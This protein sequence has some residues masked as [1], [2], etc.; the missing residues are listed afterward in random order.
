MACSRNEQGAAGAAASVP[1]NG[2][3]VVLAMPLEPATLLAPFA[4]NDSEVNISAL[5]FPWLTSL[6]FRG[7]LVHTP[8]LAQR[9]ERSA[10]G[11]SITYY[12]KPAKWSDGAPVRASDAVFTWKLVANVEFGSPK[13]EYTKRIEAME[14]VSDHV[15][16]VTF[17]NAYWMDNQLSD[18]NLGVIP[19]HVYKNLEPR[20]VRGNDRVLV[21]VGHGPFRV[22]RREGVKMF[23]LER[24]PEC[25]ISPVPHL[26]QLIFTFVGT[27]EAQR[28]ALMTGAVDAIDTSRM[29]DVEEILKKG[30]FEAAPRGTRAIEFIT[31]NNTHPLFKDTKVRRALTASLD[32]DGMNASVFRVKKAGVY[33]KSCGT[34]PPVLMKAT[35]GEPGWIPFDRAG[36]GA[37]L[38]DL[39]WKRGATGV[40][41]REGKKFEFTLLVNVETPRRVQYAR[42]I[43]QDLREAGIGVSIEELSFDALSARINERKFEAAIFGYTASLQLKQGE[44][45]GTGQNFNFA[46]YSNPAVDALNAGMRDE[47]DEGR[48]CAALRQM[49]QIVYDDQ[50]VTFLAWYSRIAVHHNRIRDYKPSILTFIDTIDRC[51]V[52]RSLQKMFVGE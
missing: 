50:P 36:A 19:E 13:L 5:L 20:D 48:L 14:A 52:P 27:P 42:M 26:K 39:G 6:E 49:Q 2:D 35:L 3:R 41:E 4:Y 22:V 16:R 37:A 40:R 46:N 29:E 9:Y 18:A 7:G 21:P 51:Y 12:L 25:V 31:W 47:E 44:V 17:K 34:V 32:I 15:L 1:E 43:Q 23:V 33:S 45:W 24:N 11:R 8:S 30:G 38:D 10:D 28:N